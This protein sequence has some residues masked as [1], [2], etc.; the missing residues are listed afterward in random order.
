MKNFESQFR[1]ESSTSVTTCRNERRL[2]RRRLARIAH[3]GRRGQL[4]PQ[5]SHCVEH[6]MSIFA[7][8]KPRRPG[9]RSMAEIA[10]SPRIIFAGSSAIARLQKDFLG[11][12]C[13]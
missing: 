3:G 5:F 7:S 10:V 9:V 11:V 1:N 6:S 13:A 8:M 4:S 2:I 12:D